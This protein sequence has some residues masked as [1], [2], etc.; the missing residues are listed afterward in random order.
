MSEPENFLSRWSRRKQEVAREEEPAKQVAAD[1]VERTEDSAGDD[2]RA[3]NEGDKPDAAT[4]KEPAFDL[5][6]LPSIESITAETD[7][8]PFL[9]AGVP[10][11]LRNAALRRVWVADPKIRDFIGMA[12]NQWD[13][14]GAAEVPGFDFSVPAGDLRRL[15]AEILGQDAEA[16]DSRDGDG[17][18][19]EAVNIA[20]EQIAQ[21]NEVLSH[22]NV[23]GSRPT[24]FPAAAPTGTHNAAATAPAE[25]STAPQQIRES[26]ASQNNDATQHEAAKISRRS[27]G[28]A[29]PK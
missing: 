1:A 29:M 3:K 4:P 13:F 15:V 9:A 25:N 7:I 14:T 20:S 27:H 10:T 17:A 8:R 6:E 19:K 12:E 18:S 28:G 22:S 2:A 16:R 5:S 23:I 26:S 24:N 11:A 21:S